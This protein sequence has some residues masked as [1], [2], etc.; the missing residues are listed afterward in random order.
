MYLW[1]GVS[2]RSLVGGEW[3]RISERSNTQRR[4]CVY[5]R[6]RTRDASIAR[7]KTAAQPAA[8]RQTESGKRFVSARGEVCVGPEQNGKCK[9]KNRFCILHP[10]SIPIPYCMQRIE[11]TTGSG[12]SGR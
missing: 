10:H 1:F 5:R 2:L 3:P 8:I 6:L 4:T 12:S 7:S 9:C 11:E